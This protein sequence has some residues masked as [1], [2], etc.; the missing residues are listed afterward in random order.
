M[1]GFIFIAFGGAFVVMRVM[2]GW[3]LDCFGGVKVAIVFLLV[4]MVGL[5]LLWQ[6]LGAWVALAGAAL[7]GAG[8]LLIFFALGVEVVK[9][10][11]L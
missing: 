2:F 11:F 9:C 5:L 8:C 4:E 3:M 7:I 1:A 10:V 6:A